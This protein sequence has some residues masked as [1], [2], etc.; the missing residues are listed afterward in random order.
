MRGDGRQ[1]IADEPTP[2][3]AAPGRSR[4]WL[5][6]A[7]GIAAGL[8]LCALAYLV[9][10]FINPPAPDPTP[11]ARA[12]CADLTAQRYDS[13]YSLLSPSLQAQGTETQFSASQRQLDHLLGPARACSVSGT[14]AN[15]DVAGVTLTLQRANAAV[16]RVSLA[17]QSGKWRIAS[18]DQ[19]V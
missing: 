1:S 3:G 14:S 5:P 13:L 15:G 16:A 8:A 10:N 9:L 12:I 11:T 18:Y 19:T 17:Q 2:R 6:I 4:R 7:A